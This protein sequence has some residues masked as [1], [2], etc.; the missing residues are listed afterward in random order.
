[1]KRKEYRE[2]MVKSNHYRNQMA[3]LIL[4]ELRSINGGVVASGDTV[5]PDPVPPPPPT[6]D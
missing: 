2:F 1:M 4:A 5:D 6:D 3:T